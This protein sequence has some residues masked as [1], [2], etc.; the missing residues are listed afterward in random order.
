MEYNIAHY[1]SDGL[2][3][4]NYSIIPKT[5][6]FK[7]TWIKVNYGKYWKSIGLTN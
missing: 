4:L 6:L 2:T 3:S 7:C 5:E 1:K